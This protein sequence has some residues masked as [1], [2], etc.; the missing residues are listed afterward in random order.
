MWLDGTEIQIVRETLRISL[1]E[2]SAVISSPAS[3]HPLHICSRRGVQSSRLIATFLLII[4]LIAGT[5][6]LQALAAP[7]AVLEIEGTATATSPM[8][9]SIAVGD[10]F[11]W[12]IIL[13]LDAGSTGSTPSY[14]NTFNDSVM[15]FT[16]TAAAGNTGTWDPTGVIWP[17]APASNVAANTNSNGSY[18]ATPT[19]QCT[20]P[21]WDVI[22]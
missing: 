2:C 19:D 14:G 6:G 11:E 21:C 15:S 22:F 5:F 9:T 8:G 17:I 1:L 16:L 12:S 7:S 10:V 13:D 4:G 18:R 20:R 3:P